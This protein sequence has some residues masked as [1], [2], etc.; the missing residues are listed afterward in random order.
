VADVTEPEQVEALIERAMDEFGQL[1]VVI[2][3]AGFGGGGTLVEGE[4]ERWKAMLLAN[5]YGAAI[6]V[7]HALKPMLARGSGHVV[8]VSSVA[9]KRVPANRNHMYAATKFAVEALAEGLR[10][11][12]AGKIRVTAI[13]P[14]MV[15]TEFG[16]WKVQALAPED[17][18]RGI[19][20]AL[21]QPDRVAINQLMLRPVTQD[22]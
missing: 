6:T 8:M 3:N 17:V 20:F 15:D 13:Q 2:A 12:V 16:E 19:V 9:G 7:H 4:P 21:E 5:V 11:E 18:A 14:G 10:Q 22:F 1:D